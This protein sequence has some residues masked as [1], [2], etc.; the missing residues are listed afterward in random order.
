MFFAGSSA[1][2]RALIR[3]VYVA[4]GVACVVGNFSRY[5][6]ARSGRRLSSSAWTLAS[7][8]SFLGSDVISHF[9]WGFAGCVAA[10]GFVVAVEVDGAVVGPTDGLVV[11]SAPAAGSANAASCTAPSPSGVFTRDCGLLGRGPAGA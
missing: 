4:A 3:T 1:Q 2:A 5:F 10:T 8:A 9:V 11:G 7:L 6:S